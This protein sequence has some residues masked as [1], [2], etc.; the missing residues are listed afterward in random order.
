MHTVETHTHFF[1]FEEY[2]V[3]EKYGTCQYDVNKR[4]EINKK[5][6]GKHARLCLLQKKNFHKNEMHMKTRK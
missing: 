4:E 6:T 2:S 5:K 1:F 3:Y